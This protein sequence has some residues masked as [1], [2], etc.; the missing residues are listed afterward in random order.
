MSKKKK[1]DL[2]NNPM[3]EAAMKALTPEQKEEYK[4]IGE[5]MFSTD[6]LQTEK[7][8]ED[9]KENPDDILRYADEALKAGLDPMDL[10]KKEVQLLTDMRGPKWY[11]EYDYEEDEVPKAE[12][13]LTH[14]FQQYLAQETAKMEKMTPKQR[15]NYIKKLEKKTRKI[16]NPGANAKKI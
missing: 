2:F 6:Y 5:Y 1:T 14:G 11:E 3:V 10:S 13:G 7:K 8:R 15:R 16:K 4:R 9:D 12:F